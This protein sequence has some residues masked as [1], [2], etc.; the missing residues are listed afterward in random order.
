[1][2]L[3]DQHVTKRV[4]LRKLPPDSIEATIELRPERISQVI[5]I[6]S[7]SWVLCN[8]NE[9]PPP[10]LVLNAPHVCC[11]HLRS[12][13]KGLWSVEDPTSLQ[14]ANNASGPAAAVER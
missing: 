7:A 6:V 11:F 2:I 5:V 12:F 1:M 8:T 3:S 13:Q 10:L 14:L 4:E 9:Q